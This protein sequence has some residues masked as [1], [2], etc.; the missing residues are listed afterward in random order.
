[1]S[2][3][4]KINMQKEFGLQDINQEKPIPQEK[5][6]EEKYQEYV[7]YVARKLRYN[8]LQVKTAQN[9]EF[10]QK[11][12]EKNTQPSKTVPDQSLPMREI[13]VRFAKGLPV[14]VKTPVYNGEEL[15]PDVAKLDLVDIQELREAIRDEISGL[16]DDVNTDIKNKRKAKEEAKNALKNENAS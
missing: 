7:D 2:K 1:M 5:S 6:Q 12:Y 3:T 16:T 4:N 11:D 15:L 13:L 10:F 14:G 8:R 9:A